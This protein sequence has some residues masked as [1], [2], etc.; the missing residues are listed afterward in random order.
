MHISITGD[1]G[2]GKSTVA[3]ELCKYFDFTYL[4]TGQIQRNLAQEMGMNTLEFNKFTDDNLHIDDIIDNKLKEVNDK[5]EPH[6]LDSRLAWHFVKPTFKIYLMALDV[7]SATRVLKD[8]KRIGEPEAKDIQSVIK[9]LKERRNSESQRFEKN[10]GIKPKLFKDYDAI[11][12]TSTASIEQVTQ[13]LI[14]LYKQ[15]VNGVKTPKIWLS[16]VRVLPTQINENDDNT[17]ILMDIEHLTSL[18]PIEC[19]LYKREFYLYSGM[20]T[21]KGFL[22]TQGP[23]LPVDI[24]AKEGSISVNV[25]KFIQENYREEDLPIFEHKYGI[26]Y[27]RQQVV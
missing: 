7:V 6:I 9:E 25:E 24:K 19:V 14:Y 27:W 13:L 17:Q 5:V 10:Y 23:F 26:T 2:S 16:P 8:D 4:S 18:A 11:V 12:D 21:L 1:L 3:K 22:Q 15:Y 20:S